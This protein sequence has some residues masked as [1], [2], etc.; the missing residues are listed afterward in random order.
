MIKSVSSGKI[1]MKQIDPDGSEFSENLAYVKENLA[2]QD[3]AKSARLSEIGHDVAFLATELSKLTNN[4]FKS[5][6]VSYEVEVG[7]D[8]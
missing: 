8:V 5:L 4:T 7:L 3:A 2:N 1:V 6:S